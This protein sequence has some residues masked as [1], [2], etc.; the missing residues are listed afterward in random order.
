MCS[1]TCEGGIRNSQRSVLQD[2]VYGGLDCTGDSVREEMCY[3]DPCPGKN[4]H[5]LIAAKNQVGI[6]SYQS[7]N[8]FTIACE[9]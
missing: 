5:S 3:P 1:K 8:V 2:A 7:P 6:L 4:I 9:D